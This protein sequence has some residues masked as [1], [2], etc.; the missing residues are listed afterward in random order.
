MK[1]SPKASEAAE[2]DLCLGSLVFYPD[3]AGP[4]IRFKRYAPGLRTRGVRMRVF[5]GAWPD[6]EQGSDSCGQQ[7]PRQDPAYGELGR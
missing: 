2:L 7:V 4:S 5:S 1:G 3:Y 6:E